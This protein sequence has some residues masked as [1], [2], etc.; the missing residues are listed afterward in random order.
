MGLEKGRTNNPAGRP[1]GTPNKTNAELRERIS[2]FVSDRWEQFEGDFDDLEPKERMFFFE[3]LMAY[4][5]PKLQ[6]VAVDH[7]GAAHSLVW[8][9]IK[10][11]V[12]ST[13]TISI[14]IPDNGRSFDPS[15]MTDQELRAAIAEEE[16]T[17]QE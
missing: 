14:I 7:Q 2:N 10:T 6:A 9:E 16:R 12:D 3:K 17:G 1:K 11:Y 8:N 13:P 15:K 4:T 5:L